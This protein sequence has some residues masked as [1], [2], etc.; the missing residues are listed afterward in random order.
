MNRRFFADQRDYFKYSILRHLLAHDIRCTV[1]WMLTPDEN[2]P[3]NRLEDYVDDP[4]N[5]QNLDPAVFNFLN[6]QLRP[7]P[8]NMDATAQQQSPIADCQFHWDPFPLD[9]NQRLAY[10]DACINTA[11]GSQLVFV[12][13]DTGP[14]S[15]EPST[16]QHHAQIHRMERNRSHLPPRFLN[17]YIPTPATE[18][19]RKSDTPQRKTRILARNT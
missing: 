11:N 7:G 3:A 13:P 14:G 1:C 4:A 16:R 15:T 12:D 5:W 19:P 8:P 18:R 9:Q 10:F 17:P 6:A 2:R